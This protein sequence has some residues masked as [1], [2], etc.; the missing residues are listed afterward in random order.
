MISF[1]SPQMLATIDTTTYTI[2]NDLNC[3]C[4]TRSGR[5]SLHLSVNAG[6]VSKGLSISSSGIT[7]FAGLEFGGLE[8]DR[9]EF[10]ELENDVLKIGKLTLDIGCDTYTKVA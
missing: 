10:G 6:I 9:L 5:P 7:E 2:E 4:C 3:V 8:T 1:Y